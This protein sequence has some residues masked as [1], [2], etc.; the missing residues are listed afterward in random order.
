M[1]S[2]HPRSVSALMLA[3]RSERLRILCMREFNTRKC[4]AISIS[5]SDSAVEYTRRA[6]DRSQRHDV[7]AAYDRP[8]SGAEIR[9]ERRQLR[10]VSRHHVVRWARPQRSRLLRTSATR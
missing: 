9:L 6:A 2:R 10:A 7:A 4:I 8:I 3:H 5:I 1:N